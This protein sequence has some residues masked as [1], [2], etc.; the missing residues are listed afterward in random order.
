MPKALTQT[1]PQS[2]VVFSFRLFK[3]APQWLAAIAALALLLPLALPAA[4]A[5]GPAASPSVPTV[6]AKLTAQRVE[7][8][9]G[10]TQLKPAT[11]GKPGQ[12]IEYNGTYQNN[13]SGPVSKLLVTLPVPVGTTYVAGSAEPALGAQASVDGVRFAPVPLMR[14]IRAVD[15]TERREPVPL[16][17]YRA[18]RWEISTLAPNASAEVKMR[19]SID[20]FV[21][22]KSSEAGAIQ[23]FSVEPT[24]ALGVPV[25]SAGATVASAKP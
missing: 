5:Q 7:T 15:G 3:T 24:A 10:K 21:G 11:D 4:W 6:S 1:Q 22:G 25:A 9:D 13:G 12:V 19:V 18:I 23:L 20:A 14:R 16:A 8:V 2:Q 17:D